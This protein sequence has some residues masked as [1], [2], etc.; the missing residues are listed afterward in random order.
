ML[1]VLL[2][3]HA[4][5]VSNITMSAHSHSEGDRLLIRGIASVPLA[6]LY[7]PSFKRGSRYADLLTFIYFLL[8]K[9]ITYIA[10]LHLQRDKSVE[11][12]S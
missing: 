3:W 11:K 7:M 1:L 4:G 2:V 12:I 5:T 10:F 6:S 8:R 9:V